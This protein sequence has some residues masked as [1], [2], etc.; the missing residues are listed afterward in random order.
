M[1]LSSTIWI[2]LHPQLIKALI[3]E[4]PNLKIKNTCTE[5]L[6]PVFKLFNLV[7]TKLFQFIQRYILEER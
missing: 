2:A 4:I 3:H 5:G 6:K 7:F 1:A